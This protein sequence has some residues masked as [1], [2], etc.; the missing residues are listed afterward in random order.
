MRQMG[1]S[2]DDVTDPSNVKTKFPSKVSASEGSSSSNER[3]SR[4]SYATPSSNYESSS[5]ASRVAKGPATS[6]TSASSNHYSSSSSSKTPAPSAA[7]YMSYSEQHSAPAVS[8]MKAPVATSAPSRSAR[9]DFLRSLGIDNMDRPDPAPASVAQPAVASRASQEYARPGARPAAISS[10]DSED[11]T[12]N[13]RTMAPRPQPD[14]MLGMRRASSS[15]L[16]S[17]NK[18]SANPTPSAA[19][20][21]NNKPFSMM[22]KDLEG[23]D[24]EEVKNLGNKS[25]ED[26]DY[27]KAVRLYSRA[28]E[29]DPRSAALYSN[30]SACYLQASKQMGIDT[31]TMA[32]RDADKVIEIRP[33]WFKGYSRRGDALFKLERFSEA[34]IAYERGLA[35]D[36]NNTNLMHSLG[37]ARNAAGGMGQRSQVNS[38]STKAAAPES[39]RSASGKSARELLEEMKTSMRREASECIAIGDDYREQELRKYR[40]RS[41]SSLDNYTSNQNSSNINSSS[42]RAGNPNASSSFAEEPEYARANSRLD[43]SQIPQEYSSS[44]AAAYQQSLLEE[45]RR[46]KAAKNTSA[47]YQT[48]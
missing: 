18:S 12:E 44:V 8:P 15:M 31:R 42:R 24:A 40:D 38:W 39:L 48:Y 37:E 35:L 32:L 22:D 34:A 30:R 16:P 29:M 25:F 5:S 1:I 43:R 13:Y 47:A 2:V 20:A 11:S 27:R 33:D 10:H 9:E 7:G 21:N 45:Y 4:A 6:T 46:K 26:G 19:A 14:V 23:L 41:T 28:I 3:P 36:P 17:N